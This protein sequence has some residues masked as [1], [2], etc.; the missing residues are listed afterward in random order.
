MHKSTWKQGESRFAKIFGTVRNA[1]S[2]GNS[3]MTRSDSIHPELFL[4]SKHG[5]RHAIWTL[6]DEEKPKAVKENKIPVIGIH[7]M[8]SP[9]ILI[10][11]HSDDIQ[12]V[13][14]ILRKQAKDAKD[15]GAE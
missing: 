15:K 11:I 10:V 9:G 1:L 3:K 8:N 12:T 14:A 6:Y 13:A 2:G 4:S 7:R 5:K